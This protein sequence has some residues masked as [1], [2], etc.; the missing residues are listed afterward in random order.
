MSTQLILGEDGQPNSLVCLGGSAKVIWFLAAID[1]LNSDDD[2]AS[3]RDREL[4]FCDNLTVTVEA[5]GLSFT[6]AR[7]FLVCLNLDDHSRSSVCA[8][9]DWNWN[10]HGDLDDDELI[11]FERVMADQ[12]EL[13][14]PPADLAN[15]FIQ[16]LGLV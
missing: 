11:V 9:P 1:H 2:L 14:N 6:V 10:E 8:E 12:P 15:Y 5:E 3:E 7:R 16:R 13:F 4:T